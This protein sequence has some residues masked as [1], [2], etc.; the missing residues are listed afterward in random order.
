M[1]RVSLEEAKTFKTLSG[2]SNNFS[3]LLTVRS[4]NE[5]KF[6]GRR[7]HD[8]LTSLAAFAE[9]GSLSLYSNSPQQAEECLEFITKQ[10]LEIKM[11]LGDRFLEDAIESLY[12]EKITKFN[13]YFYMAKEIQSSGR[14]AS[15]IRLASRADQG[16]INEWYDSFNQH[17]DANWDTPDLSKSP[18]PRL[19]LATNNDTFL[20]GCANTLQNDRRLWI[21]RLFVLPEKRK[22][23]I[24]RQ[25]MTG[26]ENDA[27][28]EKKSVD[29]L[30]NVDNTGAIKF[31]QKLGYKVMAENAFWKF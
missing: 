14:P 9:D 26:I 13:P 3:D 20:G 2:S 7:E 17:E 27:F 8:L 23:G 12:T 10:N 16:L 15:S 19:Y 21:G 22:S 24:A 11:I 25:L 1:K 18:L 30:V 29:L 28:V 6:W 4:I 5:Y 31:Y